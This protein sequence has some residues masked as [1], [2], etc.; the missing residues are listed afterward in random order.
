ML[1]KLRK[2]FIKKLLK[3]IDGYTFTGFSENEPIKFYYDEIIDRY[4]IGR[5]SDTMY[6]SRPTLYGWCGYMSRYLP[7]GKTVNGFKYGNEPKEVSF[8]K[9]MYGLMDSI[10]K[11]YMETKKN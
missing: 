11:E 9:W 6:Y 8:E 10:H 7:W 2:W 3:D 5:R 1:E 4:I